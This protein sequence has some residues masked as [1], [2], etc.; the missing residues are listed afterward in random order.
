MTVVRG[1]G[2]LQT[3]GWL[4]QDFARQAGYQKFQRPLRTDAEF[5]ERGR[6]HYGIAFGQ[7]YGITTCTFYDSAAVDGDE[8]LGGSLAGGVSGRKAVRLFQFEKIDHEVRRA[9]HG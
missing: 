3:G 7:G 6:D 4:W 1:L 8:D 2:W 5:A 9:D